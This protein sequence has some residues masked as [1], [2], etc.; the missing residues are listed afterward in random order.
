VATAQLLVHLTVVALFSV[1]RLFAP[2][3]NAL[4]GGV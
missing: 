2:N 3:D 4:G 1:V